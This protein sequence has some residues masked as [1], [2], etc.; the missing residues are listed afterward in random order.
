M[1]EASNLATQLAAGA[2]AAFGGVKRLMVESFTNNARGADVAEPE[3]IP[4]WVVRRTA[5][6]ESRRSW[7]SARRNFQEN[8]NFFFFSFLRLKIQLPAI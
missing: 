3:Y 2:T 1:S 8:R 6:K 7:R 5:A 4:R